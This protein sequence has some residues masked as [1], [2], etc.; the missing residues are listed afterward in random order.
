MR[1]NSGLS[2]LGLLITL[3][4]LGFIAV[5][6]FKLVPVY[7]EYFSIKKAL[8]GTVRSADA[9]NATVA[10]LR[11]TFDLRISADYI[12]TVSAKDLDITKEGGLPVLSVN[13][14]VQVPL[15]ANV[16]FCIDFEANSN[17]P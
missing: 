11:R 6:G 16:S 5:I 15:V 2:L 4:V 14:K 12:T 13:Y 8:V 10:D 9:K 1:R 17:A 7:I 3:A